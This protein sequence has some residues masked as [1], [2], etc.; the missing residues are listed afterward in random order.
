MALS[1]FLLCCAIGTF[2]SVDANSILS[3]TI[4]GTNCV[5]SPCVVRN[6][7]AYTFTFQYK[8]LR[9]GSSQD[10][11]WTASLGKG[12]LFSSADTLFANYNLCNSGGGLVLQKAAC[13]GF[14]LEQGQYYTVTVSSLQFPKVKETKYLDLYL[15]DGKQKS[16]LSGLEVRP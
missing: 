10:L 9:T 7:N 8:V 14:T 1:I 15:S 5:R 13:S 4:S 6:G 3:P 11:S 2:N 16:R 12:S